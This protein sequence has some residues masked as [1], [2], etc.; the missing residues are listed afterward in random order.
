MRKFQTA[1]GGTPSGTLDVATWA[2]L[3]VQAPGGVLQPDGSVSPVPGRSPGDPTPQPRP[4]VPTHPTMKL[5]VARSR[6]LRAARE[7]QRGRRRRRAPRRPALAGADAVVFDAAT[8]T[9]VRAFQRAHPPLV[10]DGQVG[11]NTWAALDQLV[12][13]AG[14]G[15]VQQ[16]GTPDKA[17]GKEFATPTAFDWALEPDRTSPTS[18]A[19]RVTYDFQNDPARPVDD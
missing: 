6:G 10:V 1:N 13:G 14:A 4:G 5:D 9:A 12:P 3:D 19:A 16:K 7:T 18:L 2:Q 15:R 8:D 17:R 11:L